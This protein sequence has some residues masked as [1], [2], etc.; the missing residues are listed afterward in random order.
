MQIELVNNEKESY[1]KTIENI[2]EELKAKEKRIG[3]L[4][5]AVRELESSVEMVKRE[6]ALKNIGYLKEVEKNQEN[7]ARIEEM[8]WILEKNFENFWKNS[9]RDTPFYQIKKNSVQKLN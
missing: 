2:H 1:K 9:K 7:Q 6:M 4:K 5:V 3:E 8:V